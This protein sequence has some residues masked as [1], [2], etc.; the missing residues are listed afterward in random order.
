ME[1]IEFNWCKQEIKMRIKISRNAQKQITN[2][3]VENTLR[4]RFEKKLLDYLLAI[5]YEKLNKNLS[6]Y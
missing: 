5:V 3:L 4:K 6:N 2:A 1:E